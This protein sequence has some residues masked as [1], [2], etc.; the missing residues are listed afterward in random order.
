M[1]KLHCNGVTPL[2]PSVAIL[3]TSSLE[4][5]SSDKG[6]IFFRCGRFSVEHISS[7][8]EVESAKY[9]PT[10]LYFPP[11]LGDLDLSLGLVDLDLVVTEVKL[12]SVKLVEPVFTEGAAT[13]VVAASILVP[14]NLLLL[15]TTLIG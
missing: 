14:Y 15:D 12:G 9:L 6:T 4:L 11:K 13:A 3:F 7:S 5:E 10:P 8:L 1:V 2:Q